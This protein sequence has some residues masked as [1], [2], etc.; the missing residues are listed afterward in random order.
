[1][2]NTFSILLLVVILT[3]CETVVDLKYNNNQSKVV[4]EGNITNEAGPYFV[5]VTKSISLSNTG[6]YPTIDNAIVTLSDDAGNSETLIAQGNG[7]YKTNVLAGVAG[8]TYTLSVTAEG[9]TYIAQSTMPQPVPF[10][11][12]KVE[13]VG[14]A[15]EK[16]YNLIPLYNDPVTEGNNYRFVVSV[17]NKILNQQFVQN[18]ELKNGGVNSLKLE[19]NN[20][21]VKFEPNDSVALVMQCVDKN[22]AL[23]Y[24]TLALIADSGPGGGSTPNNPRTNISNGALGLFSAHTVQKKSVVLP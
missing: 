4:I 16:E 9:Q 24:K 6:S 8:R 17:N 13:E 15:N 23:Y 19:I 22:V 12:I 21:L 1:M 5:K 10:D 11:S 18:D 20:D 7:V 3:S 14:S 2:K